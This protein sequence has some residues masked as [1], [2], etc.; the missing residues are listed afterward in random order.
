MKGW[1]KKD[2]CPSPVALCQGIEQ[3][4]RFVRRGSWPI[5][6]SI[7]RKDGNCLEECVR[8]SEHVHVNVSVSG[9]FPEDGQGDGRFLR[10]EE[11]MCLKDTQCSSL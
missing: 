3:H 6:A 8:E 5:P 1:R 2:E 7:L 4:A 9:A 10:D 11:E